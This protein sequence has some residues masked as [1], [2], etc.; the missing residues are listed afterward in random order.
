MKRSTIR[1]GGGKRLQAVV[2]DG[3]KAKSK[4]KIGD[5]PL[6]S[7]RRNKGQVTYDVSIRTFASSLLQVLCLPKIPL[8]PNTHS[9]DPT[10]PHL[11][12]FPQASRTLGPTLLPSLF[13]SQPLYNPSPSKLRSGPHPLLHTLFLSGP[14]TSTRSG[15]A[16]HLLSPNLASPALGPI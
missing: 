11:N 2:A 15:F 9:R 3:E 4:Q 16:I 12:F 7:C 13:P 8:Y 5:V 10:S 1:E 14:S 6:G